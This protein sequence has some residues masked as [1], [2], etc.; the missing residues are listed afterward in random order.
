MFTVRALVART[1]V[2]ATCVL[3]GWTASS[4]LAESPIV[5]PASDAP[6]RFSL[7]LPRHD[8]AGTQAM[9]LLNAAGKRVG[10]GQLGAGFTQSG[11]ALP[12][13]RLTAVLQPG[14]GED[15]LRRLRLR[16]HDAETRF[17]I[18]EFEGKSLEASEA[19]QPVLRYN[20]GKIVA[21]SVPEDDPRRERACY[22]HPVWGMDGELL[23]DDFPRDHYHHHGIF[24]T[25]PHVIIDG[26]EHSLWDDRGDLRQRFQRWL[27]R[28]T[29]PVACVIGVENGWFEGDRQ[30]LTERVWLT[31]HAAEGDYRAVDVDLFLN[32]LVPITLR[33]AEGKSYGGFTIRFRPPSADHAVI[34]VPE[35]VTD[36]DLTVTRLPW[37]DYTTHFDGREQPSGATI[38]ISDSHPDYPPTW[39]TRH[40]GAMCVGWPGVESKTLEPGT[41][42]RLSYRVWIH[43][44][45][46]EVEELETVYQSYLQ[47]LAVGFSRP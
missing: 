14:T 44:G 28:E 17:A 26:K 46:P 13:A 43:R 22:V 8:G 9:S 30:V 18:E 1:V 16:E 11:D 42:T 23:T 12:G 25:W 32:P 34:T 15:G 4:S 19:E 10:L 37:A 41:S 45:Q 21:E 38:L 5:A 27:A 24:W 20:F 29:G 6:L 3:G 40:Y 35:G 33:G 7:V 31:I 2:L 36:T 39:L 47:G